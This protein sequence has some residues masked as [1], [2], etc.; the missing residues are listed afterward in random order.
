MQR[1]AV[2]A[3]VAVALAG[4]AAESEPQPDESGGDGNDDDSADASAFDEDAIEE[5]FIE[6]FNAMR[7]ER[8]LG[9]VYR[10][11]FLSEMGD[12]HAA[13]MAEHD[14]VGHVQPDTN[15]GITDRFRD[16][17]LLPEC[18]IDVPGTGQY[19]PGAENVATA[20]VGRVT[21]PGTDETVTI[22]ENDDV[23]AFLLD[24][25][26]TSESHREVMVLPTIEAVG[27]GVAV[28]DDGEIFAALEF[29]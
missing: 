12:E 1:R 11:R 13:N 16:R 18:E 25:W 2:L 8:S 19:Y 5:L 23:A 4:C 26:M 7:D 14:Y 20:A 3:G 24:S 29:C 15:M 21:H 10:D 17:G 6:R 27:L 28:R 9:D 22:S